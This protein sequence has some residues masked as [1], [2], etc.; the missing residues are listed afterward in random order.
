[1]LEGHLGLNH[2]VEKGKF[3][4]ENEFF[5]FFRPGFECVFLEVVVVVKDCEGSWEL[6]C[7]ELLTD[8][9]VKVVLRLITE[10]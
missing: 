1:M 7:L 3:L 4:H 8:C 5:H 6:S 2:D 9:R 10:G